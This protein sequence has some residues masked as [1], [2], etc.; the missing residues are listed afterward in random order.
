MKSN[1]NQPNAPESKPGLKPNGKDDLK[2]LPMPELEKKLV[3]G[4]NAE[5]ETAGGEDACELY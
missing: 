2:S 5:K 4:R 3:S 1:T